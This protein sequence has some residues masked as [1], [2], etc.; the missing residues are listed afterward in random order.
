MHTL[1]GVHYVHTPLTGVHHVHI[2][3]GVHHVHILTGVHYAANPV[4]ELI[5]C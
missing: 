2:V 1:T 5:P 4:S 3:T